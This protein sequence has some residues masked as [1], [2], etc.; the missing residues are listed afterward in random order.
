MLGCG[1]G[2]CSCFVQ[3]CGQV[4]AQLSGAARA[5]HIPRHFI[6]GGFG[7]SVLWD[8]ASPVLGGLIAFGLQHYWQHVSNGDDRRKRRRENLETLAKL[9]FEQVEFIQREGREAAI[10]IKNDMSDNLKD[11]WAMQEIYFPEIRDEFRKIYEASTNNIDFI[12]NYMSTK[13]VNVEIE[14]DVDAWR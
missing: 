8:L 5:E 9:V 2:S 7:M 12:L 10:C 6:D 4:R 14:F 1:R 13:K 11:I 3:R